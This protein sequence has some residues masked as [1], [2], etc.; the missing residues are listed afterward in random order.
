MVGGVAACWAVADSW[1][2][3]AESS[4]AGSDLERVFYFSNVLV[5]YQKGVN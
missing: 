5:V 2:V 4:I 3:G 1:A